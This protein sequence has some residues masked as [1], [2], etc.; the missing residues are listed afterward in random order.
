MAR[1]TL[2]VLLG[3]LIVLS[4]GATWSRENQAK[5]DILLRFAGLV[6]HKWSVATPGVKTR[7][8]T[9][10]KV[11]ALTLD[12]CG[13]VKGGGFD[14][15]L[16]NYLAKEGIPATLFMSGRWIEANQGVLSEL[17][18]NPLWEIENHGFWHKPCSVSGR[19]AY[20]IGGTRNIGEVFDEIQLNASKIE[21]ATGRRPRHYRPG[22]AFCDEI[23]VEIAEALGQEVVSY[24]VLGDAGAAYSARQ[25]KEA[26]LAAPAG[27][28]V[29]LH[30]NHPGGGTADGLR[31]ALPELK[32]RGFRFVRLSEYSLR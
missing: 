14:V 9:A 19:Q 29:L 21:T 32:R 6:P 7:L 31:Q 2:L 30:M 12:A 22:T 8:N 23:C 24:S 27:S 26:M 3:L 10:E 16:M 5:E 18:K 15:T 13:G 20:G 1:K 25:V 4:P 28:I 11:L 17:V